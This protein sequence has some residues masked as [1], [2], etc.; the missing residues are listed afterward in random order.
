MSDWNKL[1]ACLSQLEVIAENS[2]GS[3]GSGTG[4]FDGNIT[5]LG[6]NSI[7]L[8]AGNKSTG[9]QRV[10]V[11]N[12]DT[13]LSNIPTWYTRYQ[14][15]QTSYSPL[16]A[17]L[18]V[19][20]DRNTNNPQALDF[21]SGNK[22]AGTQRVTIATDDLNQST[23]NANTTN[24]LS[25]ENTISSNAATTAINAA[26]I[27]AQTDNLSF[28]TPSGYNSVNVNNKGINDN[29]FDIGTG[30][31]YLGTQRVCIATDDTN[32]A[33]INTN[34]STIATRTQ[35]LTNI[36]Y[37]FSGTKQ[38]AVA[39]RDSSTLGKCALG[40]GL[41]RQDWNANPPG[42]NT[43][44][45]TGP[46]NVATDPSYTDPGSDV[47]LAHGCPRVCIATDDVNLASINTKINSIYTIL[48]DVWDS[49][50][51]YLR[52]HAS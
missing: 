39:T 28:A 41:A 2:G 21:N 12:D 6:G 43:Y 51:H 49:T 25:V 44:I 36:Q 26:A 48:N 3:G 14:S 50:N 22:A 47:T 35:P 31:K 27:K 19:P 23:I 8:G 29:P 34:S 15:S 45:S 32:L 42:W 4:V 52:T 46:G 13:N 24:I 38:F 40:V 30:T 10:T 33:A 1:E 16:Y 18:V 17:N 11:A 37:D 5:K 20:I 7:N 9:T